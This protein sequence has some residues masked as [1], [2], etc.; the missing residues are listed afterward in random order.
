MIAAAATPTPI[1][2]APADTGPKV[3]Y[4]NYEA[5][6]TLVDVAS[7]S[8][9]PTAHTVEY[10]GHD[11]GE[12]SIGVNWNSPNS[13]TGV[14]NFQ[15]DLQTLFIT[16]N[17]SCPANGQTA[18]WVNRASPASQFVNSDPIGFTDRYTGR[19][20]AGEL[21]LTSGDNKTAYTDDDGQTWVVSAFGQGIGTGVDHQS[22]GGGPFHAPL[23][24]PTG[25]PGLYADA[26]YYCSQLP[27]SACA[28]SDDGGA[29]F[30]PI[31]EVDP[32][33]DA[34]CG[35]LHGH[36][37]VAPDGTV[38]VPFNNCDGVGSVIVSEDNGITWAI[39][40]VQNANY[41]TVSSGNFQD[42]SVGID[43]NGRVY[44]VMGSGDHNAVVATS[45]DQGRTWQNI[46]NVGTAYGLQNIAYPAAVAADAGRAAVAFYGSTTGGDFSANSFNGVWHLYISHTFDGGQ[47][48]TTTD[49]TPNAPMQRGCIWAHGGADICRNLL[50][51]FDMTVDK[52][53][54]VEVGYVNGCAGG[55]CAQAAD[56]AKGNAYTAHATI[57]RQ[58]SGRRLVA[59]FDPP[60]PLNATSAPGMPS[61]TTRR[62]GAVVHLGWS[63]ADT[64]NSPITSYQIMRGTASGAETLL[65]TVPGTQTT[66]DDTSATDTSKTYYYKVLA[67]NAVGTSCAG[68]EVAAPY[69]GDTCNGL[70]VQ[71]T[72]PGHPEQSAQGNAP[73]SL[74]IDYVAVGEPPAQTGAGNFMFKMK[75]TSLAGSL[76]INSR[77]RIVWNSYSAP[78][79]QFY[80][81]MRTNQNGV[82]SFDYGA[83]ATAVVGLV[84]GVPT[85]TRLG[86]A[87]PESNYNSDGTITIYVP[88]SAVGNPQPGDLLG[89]VNGRTFT[90][91]TPETSDLERSTLLIDHTFV[92]AQRDNG[93]PAATYTVAGAC[94]AAPKPPPYDYDGD[95]K[96]DISVFQ[97]PEGLWSVLLSSDQSGPLRQQLWGSSNL[98]DIIIPADYDG[99]GKAD[100][101]VFRPSEGNWY[102]HRN[103]GGDISI[104]WGL[105]GDIPVPADY[106]GDGKADLAVFRPTDGFWYVLRSSDNSFVA[107]PWGISTDKPVAGDYN[108]DGKADFAVAR[109]NDP[110][111]G[112]LRWY[113]AYSG[114]STFVATQWGAPTDI[115]VGG[116]GDFDADGKADL[117]VFRP[118]DGNWYILKS[119]GGFSS[120]Q[121]GLAGDIPVA[122]DYD[123]DRRTDLAVFRPGDN[124]WY[125][126]GSTSGFSGT[127]FGN[128][129]DVPVPSAYNR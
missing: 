1:P 10:L 20:F 129:T 127:P 13:E 35:G 108:G 31:V 82:P 97:G 79:E 90:G 21:T 61:V 53:G 99:D 87:L 59:A 28:R 124:H 42:P 65:A 44:F 123:G 121:W 94:Q 62:V 60:D 81:G 52:Q 101:A 30:G 96:S 85:E 102:I 111:P 2:P 104:P 33:A 39:R 54:R 84:I 114:G 18:T 63:E 95:G 115:I 12:P 7:A 64:G 72:P 80:V 120:P 58:S 76:P 4:Q 125:I 49:A 75:V 116:G 14:T 19:T 11:A 113:I 66:Y 74:A 27:H 110:S 17:D 50:D 91:D 22:I 89:A 15:S 45:D 36:I 43:N 26:V 29:T 46:F 25:V 40:H 57:A 105:A 106:D 107:V 67:V 70:I 9:G 112:Q 23:T 55:H 37:K 118:V 38:Y 24:R 56:N 117:T 68:N 92:K 77:W 34:H 3:G 32:I 47:H 71:R 93:S 98:G 119:S 128:S 41:T 48:W 109:A 69:M 78:G 5:P 122:G 126:L 16:F 6:G 88:K 83:I 86:A 51:F 8:Q 73:A 103:A 100:F